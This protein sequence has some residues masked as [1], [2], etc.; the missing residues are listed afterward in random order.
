MDAEQS[1]NY[2]CL[3]G[4]VGLKIAGCHRL[5]SKDLKLGSDREIL[6]LQDPITNELAIVNISAIRD[7]KTISQVRLIVNIEID[8][9]LSEN[10]QKI[11]NSPELAPILDHILEEEIVGVRYGKNQKGLPFVSFDLS[12]TNFVEFPY[13]DIGFSACVLKDEIFLARGFGG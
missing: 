10:P 4:L 1:L 6:Y 8:L 9:T 5:A 7:E 3:L 13:F 11:E 12:G 2:R